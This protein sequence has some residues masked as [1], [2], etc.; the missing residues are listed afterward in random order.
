MATF[1]FNFISLYDIDGNRIDSKQG[2]QSRGVLTDR[3]NDAVFSVGDMLTYPIQYS[4]L[5]LGTL[6]VNRIKY[7]VF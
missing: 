4:G 1:E 7:P 3:Q 5:Y 6:T 2:G